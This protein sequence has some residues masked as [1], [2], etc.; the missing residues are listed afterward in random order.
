MS[1]MWEIYQDYLDCGHEE[2]VRRSRCAI[3]ELRAYLGSKGIDNDNQN[4]FFINTFKLFVSADKFCAF[5][6]RDLF[7]DTFGTHLTQDEFFDMTNHGSDETF[8]K[9]FKEVFDCLSTES[10]ADVVIL[11]LTIVAADNTVKPEEK[12]LMNYLMN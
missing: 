3:A 8:K 1:D 2:R 9:N 5:K 6:E 12:E 7:N 11:G 4:A 10:Q